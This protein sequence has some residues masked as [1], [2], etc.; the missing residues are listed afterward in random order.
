M[1]RR[2]VLLFIATS[3][4]VLVAFLVPLAVLVKKSAADRATVATV[5]EIQ[6]VA[7][8]IVA[9]QP[10]DL[11]EAI[12]R[13][14][15]GNPHP[16]TIFLGDGSVIGRPVP[17]S[18]AVE[19]AAAGSSMTVEA[20]GGREVLVAV[21]GAQ[22]GTA[23]IRAF[24]PD[25]ELTH[26]VARAWFILGLLGSGLLAVSVLIADRLSRTVTVPLS[27]VARVSDQLAQGDLTARAIPGGP[28]E[29]R[30]VGS[31]LNHLA[32]Q[33]ERLI[34]NE[35]EAAAD[36]SHRLRTP[37][38]ALR[39]D[40]EALSH[41]AEQS[42]ILTDVDAVERTV[43]EIIRMARRVDPSLEKQSCDATAVLVERTRFWSALADE[44]ERR[45]HIR[46][47]ES[48]TAGVTTEDFAVCVDALLGNV[49]AHTPERIPFTV[50]LARGSDGGACLKVTDRGPG[51]PSG[52]WQRGAS[53]S[54]STGLG[55]DIVNRIATASGGEISIGAAPGGG[56]QV[57]VV[58]GCGA[59]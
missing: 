24:V 32:D 56:A 7:P 18:E 17:R 37:L 15:A 47:E 11:A 48:V 25:D 35:R 33:I 30:R 40:A 34:A 31:G 19:A 51:M 44:E 10:A 13:A 54:G 57:T 22:S 52:R 53:R 39:I 41:P 5:A 55:L 12:D 14:N 6:A 4:L 50:E 46:I 43:N 2:L 23:V 1:R 58:F 49:F 8:L 36:L 21:A 42:R 28:R 9:V 16:V 26:G 27:A 59:S 20:A 29:V 3:A 45:I 38:T